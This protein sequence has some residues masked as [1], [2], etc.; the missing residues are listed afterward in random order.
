MARALWH[1]DGA[2]PFVRPDGAADLPGGRAGAVVRHRRLGQPRAALP[3]A[4]P[5]PAHGLVRRVHDGRLVQ[6]VRVLRG[7]AD[8]LLCAAGAWPGPRALS[9]GHPLRGAQ[10]GGF[11]SVPDWPG[12][13]LQRDRHAQHGRCGPA[14][15][16]A[17]GRQRLAGAGRCAGVAGGVWP[18]GRAG[19]AVLLVAGH[20]CRCQRPGGGAVCHHD[21][22]GCLQHHPHALGD[23]RR[24]GRGV[25]L[26]RG[27]L[28]AAAGLDH[29]RL[30]R[31][32]RLGCAQH[33]PPGGLPH[34][35]F[36]G[37]FAGLC[38][39]VHHRHLVGCALLHAAQHDRDRGL[40]LA[41]GADG[42]AARAG[43]R[44][45]APR[46]GRARAGAAGPDAAVWRGIGCGFAAFARLFGQAHDF[47]EQLG[48]ARTGLGLDR[49]AERGLFHHR[50][51]GPRGCG[52][53]LACAA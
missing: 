23:L 52:P 20:L 22:G 13:G 36:G 24:G 35:V 53:V 2:G 4:V 49:G 19:A 18:Q 16:A 48:P 37:H 50:G 11:G 32:G 6:P 27:R 28:A 26:G 8:C 34:G 51:P 25:G 29:Q 44:Q 33:E 15:G 17:H 14:G 3:C 12:H 38:G 42:R 31:P 40:V 47:G 9:H 39:L 30:G 21:Q 7:L 41:G 5:V 10:L 43:A 46:R 45:T 1:R